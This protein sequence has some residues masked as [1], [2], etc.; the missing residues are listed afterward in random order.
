MGG[1][2]LIL[3]IMLYILNKYFN[4]EYFYVLKSS[5]PPKVVAAV[6]TGQAKTVKGP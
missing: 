1:G 4:K 6:D 3:L 2:V 5:V